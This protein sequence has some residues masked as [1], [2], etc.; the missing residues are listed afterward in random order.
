MKHIFKLAAA[1]GVTMLLCACGVAKNKASEAR[2]IS[3]MDTRDVVIVGAARPDLFVPELKGK[4]IAL[5]SNQTGI[6]P[7]ELVK[8]KAVE[9]AAE[10]SLPMEQA[11]GRKF[12]HSL[13]IM[14]A[15]GL[16]VEKI[17]SPEHGFR[18][19]ADAGEAVASSI[20]EA[21]GVKIVSLYGSKEPIDL[22]D[23]D[24]VVVD[25]QDV[26]LRYYTYYATMLRLMNKALEFDKEFLIM[27]RP[28]PNGMY[29]DGPIL[30]MK[31]KSGVGALP[32]PTVHGL[33]LGEMAKMAE[34]KGWLQDGRK[35]KKLT[36]IPCLNYTHQTRYQLEVAPS[37]NLPNMTSVYLYPSLCYFEA[38]P[39]SLG[40]G[41]DKP[42]QIYGHPEMKGS[43]DFTPV[44]SFGAKNPPQMDNLCHG[45]DL[46]GLAAEDIIAKGIDFSYLI[47]AYNQVGKDNPKFFRSFMEL[48]S[49]RAEIR[50][51]IEA[52][53]SPEEIKAFW[54]ADVE[55]FKIDRKPYLLYAE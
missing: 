53:K 48:L 18:G 32:I 55:Q 22:S 36:V 49:G 23:V 30:D 42:F 40:R 33:T 37:P 9:K 52:G 14:L 15:N 44:S 6:V 38:T 16:Q 50:Q 26:G 46:S 29:V 2:P 13:D 1:A 31:Y 28:N 8:G 27:D 39:V 47:D 10:L 25:I 5:L 45:Q 34:A 20:D 17:Y 4:K 24:V 41:T 51:M 54:K 19:T 11:K 12:V 7:V 35:L 3:K 43:Y 21:T